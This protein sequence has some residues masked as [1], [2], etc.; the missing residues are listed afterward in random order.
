[1][2]GDVDLCVLI[3]SPASPAPPGPYPHPPSC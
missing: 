1:M 3:H 2:A